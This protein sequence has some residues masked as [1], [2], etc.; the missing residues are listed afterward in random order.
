[1]SAIP[2]GPLAIVFA[3][4]TAALF[5]WWIGDLLGS[6]QVVRRSRGGDGPPPNI[7]DSVGMSQQAA[8]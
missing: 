6:I 8:I 7:V 5:V 1:M 2:L 3:G 4:I